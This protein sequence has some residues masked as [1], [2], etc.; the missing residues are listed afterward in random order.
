VEATSPADVVVGKEVYG[1]GAGTLLLASAGYLSF[2]AAPGQAV[3]SVQRV[4]LE[5]CY[6]ASGVDVNTVECPAR[7]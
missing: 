4:M 3:F 2:Q 7:N 6:S 1:A 5:R